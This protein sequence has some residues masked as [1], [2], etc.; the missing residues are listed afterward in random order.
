MVLQQ[1][2]PDKVSGAPGPENLS[3]PLTTGN[4]L[5]EDLA[6]TAVAPNAAPNSRSG[7]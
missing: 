1:I 6:N 3:S 7:I 2:V 5:V 4:T